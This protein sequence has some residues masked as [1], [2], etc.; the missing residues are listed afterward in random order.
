MPENPV[1]VARNI[2]PAELLEY[3]RKLKG[4]VLEEGSV[5]SHAAIVARALTIPLVIHAARITS[6]ALNGDAI[7]VDG[8]QGLVHLRPEETVA[9]SFRDK[10]AMQAA[11]QQRYSSLRDLPGTTRD[12]VTIALHMNCLLYTS[13]C[14]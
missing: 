2:G 14:V 6:E 8:D 12:G 4:V 7:L 5:G 9:R 10:T 13:R 1:L 3:G 11:A